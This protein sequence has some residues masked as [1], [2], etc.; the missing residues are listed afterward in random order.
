[1][2]RK[3]SVPKIYLLRRQRPRALRKS[4]ARS[5]LQVRIR[6]GGRTGGVFSPGARACLQYR[7]SLLRG[8][9][10]KKI[11]VSRSRRLS[12]RAYRGQKRR[13]R[14]GSGYARHLRKPRVRFVVAAGGNAFP[15]RPFLSVSV[16]FACRKNRR[17]AC[18]G[19]GRILHGGI[20]CAK[21]FLRCI[22]LHALRARARGDRP[23]LRL[24]RVRRR[25]RACAPPCRNA[26]R[27]KNGSG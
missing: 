3:S 22:R 23:P 16:R 1:M 19:A 13:G 17:Y 18:L 7:R 2:P 9:F 27:R 24:P 21:I 26:R 11:S 20:A 5:D 25:G 8:K 12:A 14:T 10:T 15:R 4:S 6:G